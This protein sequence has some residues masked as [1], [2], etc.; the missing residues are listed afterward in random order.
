MD[1]IYYAKRIQAAILPPKQNVTQFLPE[2]FVL[3]L[4]RDIVSGDFYWIKQ[5]GD[6][7][8]VVAA[9]SYNFV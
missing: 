1:S 3:Y 4:P 8:V 5:I 9:D 2:H 6:E 7:I